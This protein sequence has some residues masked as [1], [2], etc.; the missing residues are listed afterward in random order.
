MIG[1]KSCEAER[2]QVSEEEEVLKIESGVFEASKWLDSV[3]HHG[4]CHESNVCR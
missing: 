2:P 1:L 4:A 3:P